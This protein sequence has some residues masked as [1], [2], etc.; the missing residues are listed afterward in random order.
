MDDLI[1]YHIDQF[2]S[3]LDSRNQYN[4]SANI[5]EFNLGGRLLPRTLAESDEG[6]DKMVQAI[7]DVNNAGAVLSGI[8]V[9]VSKGQKVPNSV[10]PTWRT[11]IIS[12]VLGLLVL[13]SYVSL[14]RAS[15]LTQSSQALQPA[16]LRSKH[17]CSK[18]G[19]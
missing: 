7:R 18:E 6:L 5:T 13:S 2:P 11:S 3:Y 8:V 16:R 10:N 9:N 4:P 17:R 1:D 19:H 12:A 15:T 14:S